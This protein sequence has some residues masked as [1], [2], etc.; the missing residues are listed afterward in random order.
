MEYKTIE[1]KMQ[2]YKQEMEKNVLNFKRV[3]KKIKELNQE[4]ESLT[5]MMLECKILLILCPILSIVISS[6]FTHLSFKM[7]IICIALSFAILFCLYN[8]DYENYRNN[9]KKINKEIQKMLSIKKKMTEVNTILENLEKEKPDP[10]KE[11]LSELSDYKAFLK[12]KK[13]QMLKQ[14]LLQS[15]NK[16]EIEF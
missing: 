13:L 7:I 15:K 10:S 11:K 4:K 9:K 2:E 1:K 16:K 5:K 6:K 8:K 12:R 14:K 3:T